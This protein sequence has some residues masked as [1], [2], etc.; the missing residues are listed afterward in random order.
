[1][2][3]LYGN[4]DLKSALFREELQQL[5]D[6]CDKLKIVDVLEEEVREG[7]EHGLIDADLIRKYRCDDD[8]SLFV[9]G[10]QAMYDYLNEQLVKMDIP[11]K[12]W[13]L[14]IYGQYNEPSRLADYPQDK[15]D[16]VY[17]LKVIQ[18]EITYEM[19]CP[20]GTSLMNAIEQSGIRIPVH[21][22]CGY[23]GFCHSRLVSGEV[24]MPEFLD[25]RRQAD[26]IYGYI[27]PCICFPLS[28]VE[29][30]IPL[31]KN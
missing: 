24:F 25:H 11:R 8:T 14:E 7:C 21:C 4:K 5:V 1:M 20:A 12:Y 6:Q 16:E 26:K 28:D 2:L 19:D 30:E 17:R 10:P 22:R 9:C 3:M 18:G 29:I 13:R 15:K 23:C 31:Y 27:H